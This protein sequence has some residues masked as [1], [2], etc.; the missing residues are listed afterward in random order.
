M[1]KWIR[2]KHV[3]SS[4]NLRHPEEL[5]VKEIAKKFSVSQYVVYYWIE[6]GIINARRLNKGSPYWIMIDSNK[7]TELLDWVRDSTKIQKQRNQNP[8]PKL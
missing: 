8:K 4:P 2:Y 7:E 1:I 3:I 5:T 6:R